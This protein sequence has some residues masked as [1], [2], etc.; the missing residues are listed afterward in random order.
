MRRRHALPWLLGAALAAGCVGAPPRPAAESVGLPLLRAWVD[1]Q[2]VDYVSTDVSDAA[3]AAAMG[4]T[5]VPGLA[6]ALPRGGARGGLTDRVYMF[7]NQEQIN[8]FASAPR[9][10]GPSNADRAYSPLWRVVLVR[11]ARAE[12]Q[13][14]LRSEEQVLAA[15]ERGELGLTVT[16]IVANCPIVRSSDGQGLRGVH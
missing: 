16:D 15:A 13:R 4:V 5:H 7:V 11:W 8:V 1:G 12:A 2:R 14:E 9:P 3:M 10:A 6:D